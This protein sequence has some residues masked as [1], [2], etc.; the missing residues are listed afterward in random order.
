MIVRLL[1]LVLVSLLSGCSTQFT[2]K[3]GRDSRYIIWHRV[4]D[5]D[6]VCK[7]MRGNRDSIFI[8]LEGCARWT[9]YTCEI[10]TDVDTT[11]EILGHEVRH[12]FQ[13]RFHD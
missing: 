10:Y 11:H 4:S 1:V 6:S 9:A 3:E 13:G 7:A 2:Y 5:I 12:C 8:T